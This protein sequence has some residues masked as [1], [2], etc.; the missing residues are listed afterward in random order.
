VRPLANH[1]CCFQPQ[2]PIV[3]HSPSSYDCLDTCTRFPYASDNMIT[4]KRVPTTLNTQS[5]TPNIHHHCVH[6]FVAITPSNIN[7]PNCILIAVRIKYHRSYRYSTMTAYTDSHDGTK[8]LFASLCSCLPLYHWF[9]KDP[10]PSKSVLQPSSQECLTTH[11]GHR[12]ER[13]METLTRDGRSTQRTLSLVP[14][15]YSHSGLCALP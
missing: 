4:S 3:L 7:D 13:E 12:E 11:G 14:K 2:L 5:F 9:N 15:K 6:I 8:F 10:K 1:S